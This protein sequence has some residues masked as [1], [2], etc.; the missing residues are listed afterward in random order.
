MPPTNLGYLRRSAKTRPVSTRS[1]LKARW[2]SSPGVTSAADLHTVFLGF[3]DL[4]EQGEFV[5]GKAGDQDGKIATGIQMLQFNGVVAGHG[6]GEKYLH[7]ALMPGLGKF[8][9]RSGAV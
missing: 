5:P 1:G 7:L 8:H 2:K 3:L 4:G 9:H 6:F